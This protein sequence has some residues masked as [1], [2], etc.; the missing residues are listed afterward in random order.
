MSTVG[1]S[2]RAA[3][4]QPASAKQKTSPSKFS[5]SKSLAAA[6]SF[7]ASPPAAKR[8]KTEERKVKGVDRTQLHYEIDEATKAVNADHF[9][10]LQQAM[11]HLRNDLPAE[12]LTEAVS[13]GMPVYSVGDHR[14]R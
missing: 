1:G 9:H 13:A 14:V 8:V 11:N 6:R 4:K 12:M 5:P 10:T 3:G 2:K 7:G